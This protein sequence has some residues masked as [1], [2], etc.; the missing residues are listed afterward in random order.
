MSLIGITRDLEDPDLEMVEIRVAARHSGMSGAAPDVELQ[1]ICHLSSV[2]AE[3]RKLKK[4]SWV[5]QE[6]Q[7]R[8]R[9][10]V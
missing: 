9:L 10:R 4:P 5:W 7:K 3:V 2:T 6:G 8:F 1:E